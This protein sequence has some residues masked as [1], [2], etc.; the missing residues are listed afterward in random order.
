[1]LSA[2][3]AYGFDTDA[4]AMTLLHVAP[5]AL[6]EADAPSVFVQPDVDDPGVAPLLALLREA[7]DRILDPTLDGDARAAL[8]RRVA[9]VVLSTFTR[10][11]SDDVEH[12]LRRA[13][14]FVHDHAVSPSRWRTSPRAP[15]SA[16]AGC[17]T[18]SPPAARGDADAVPPRGPAGP[19]APRADLAPGWHPDGAG[20]RA[21]VAV[22]APRDASRRT[23][24]SGSGR[25]RTSRCVAPVVPR[26]DGQVVRR[27]D[28]PH[29]AGRRTP[30][31]L[32]SPSSSG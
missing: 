22:R 28:G 8:N 24:G 17:R 11:R 4:S 21:P 2:P 15:T 16:N 3:V 7:A 31:R 14:R 18:C 12:R 6:G 32:S 29:A 1:M 10:S 19:G 25:A 20:R 26:G 27:G 9:T 13:I 30:S 23:T 5:S